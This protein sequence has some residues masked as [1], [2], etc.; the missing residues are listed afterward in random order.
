[1]TMPSPSTEPPSPITIM[2]LRSKRSARAP[3]TGAS[4]MIGAKAHSW[5]RATEEAVP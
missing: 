5:T 1:M 4:R 2:S 3:A